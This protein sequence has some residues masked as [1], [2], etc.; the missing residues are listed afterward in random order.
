MSI[1]IEALHQTMLELP[2]INAKEESKPLSNMQVFTMMSI[3]L[4]Y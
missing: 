4:K 1:D 2:N 3:N